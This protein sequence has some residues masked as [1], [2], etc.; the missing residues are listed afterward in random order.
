MKPNKLRQLLNE[1]KPTIGTHVICAWPGLVEIIGQSGAFDYVE[2]VAEYSPLSLDQMER[3]GRTIELFP[4]MSS[5]I[6]VEESM[7]AWVAPR[8]IDSGIQNVLFA[9]ARSAED[10]RECV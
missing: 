7:R 1:D 3:W 10:V 5:M 8:A 2:F 4:D 6:K 9:D